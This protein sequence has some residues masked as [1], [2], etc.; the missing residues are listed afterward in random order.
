MA[1]CGP[2]L[3]TA[4]TGQIVL[5]RG[6]S[7]S[8]RTGTAVTTQGKSMTSP[9][10]GWQ[11]I[12]DMT[13][14]QGQMGSSAAGEGASQTRWEVWRHDDGFVAPIDSCL[15]DDEGVLDCCRMRLQ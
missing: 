12:L 4:P 5:D 15:Y 14:G 13:L 3:R 11:L 6:E 2:T 9:V 10:I 7:C 1:M 8:H